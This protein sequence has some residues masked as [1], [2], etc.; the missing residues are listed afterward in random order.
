VKLVNDFT[1]VCYGIDQLNSQQIETL[2]VAS[3]IDQPAYP[4]ALIIGAGT[5]LGVAHRLWINDAWQVLPTETG[6]AGFAPESSLQ[7]ALLAYLQ[8]DNAHVSLESILSGRGFYLIY[9]FLQK[10]LGVQPTEA[11]ESRLTY[12]NSAQLICEAALAGR[13][14]LCQQ[15]LELFVEIY[16][17]AAGNCVLNHY[18]L[19]EVYIAG[20]IAAKIRPALHSGAFIKAF[21]QKGLMS[22]NLGALPVKLITEENVG[23]LGALAI[24]ARAWAE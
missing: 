8:G 7:T 21:S 1:A 23:L 24:A 13:D 12:E 9:R 10:Q 16:G 17:A 15:T 6:H 11:I 19:D 14:A 4:S 18:P 20:G 5:G 22:D 2:Q 3:A